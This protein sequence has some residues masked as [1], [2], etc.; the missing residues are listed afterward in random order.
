MENILVELYHPNILDSTSSIQIS[1]LFLLLV[2]VMD[3][4]QQEPKMLE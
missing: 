3:V 4:L 2:I 1:D